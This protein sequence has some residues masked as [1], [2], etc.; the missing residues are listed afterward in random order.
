MSASDDWRSLGEALDTLRRVI[1]AARGINISAREDRDLASETAQQYFRHNRV[2]IEPAASDELQALDVAFQAIL[3]LSSAA[4]RKTSYVKQLKAIQKLY[5]RV[6]GKLALGGSG[7]RGQ[8]NY[9]PRR[10]EHCAD[11]RRTRTEC[12][13]IVQA[14]LNRSDRQQAVFLS[15]SGG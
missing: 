2:N 4:N 8:T 1:K 13:E 7:K 9:Q 12:R 3:T 6:T 11:P 10:S 14:S 5:P 15:W